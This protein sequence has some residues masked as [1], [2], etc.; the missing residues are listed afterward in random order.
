MEMAALEEAAPG[1]KGD[2]P[3]RIYAVSVDDSR[4]ISNAKALAASKDWPVTVF[5]DTKG[6]LS[7]AFGISSSPQVFV[8]DKNGKQIYSHVG[9]SA[10]SEITLLEKLLEAK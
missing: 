1:W 8:F 2:F 5:F 9:F 6:N 4:S 10:G 3:L 7:Q